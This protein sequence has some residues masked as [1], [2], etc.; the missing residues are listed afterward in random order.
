MAEFEK[1]RGRKRVY[2]LQRTREAILNAAE[3][4]FAQQG[5][6]GA[7]MEEI[8]T[9][10]G[11][12]K[13]L[14]FQYFGDKVGL[15]TQVLKR[16]DQEMGA[17]LAQS[18]ASWQRFVSA[19]PQPDQFRA[20][21]TTMV[22]TLCDY[23]FEHPRFMRILTWEMAQNWQTFTHI[24][25]QFALQEMVQLAPLFQQVYRAGVLRSDFVPLL[26]LTMIVPI[27]QAY[28]AYLPLYQQFL[29]DGDLS[30][31][32]GQARAREYLV[33]FVVAGLLHDLPMAKVEKGQ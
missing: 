10:A 18:F 29:P 7:S 31:A 33:D 28:L 14:L 2:D 15:Y 21:F 8:A 13:S 5:F 4:V 12:A 6:A 9:Q 26:Q 19:D 23:L 22:R 27:C 30:S 1:K 11:Y 32:Q 16:A 25:S 17:L 3:G 24:A 20:F